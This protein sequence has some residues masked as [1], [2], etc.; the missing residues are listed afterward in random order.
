VEPYT[1]IT[2]NT[3]INPGA[4]AEE[5]QAAGSAREMRVGTILGALKVIPTDGRMVSQVAFELTSRL[6][7]KSLEPV[8]VFA[9]VCNALHLSSDRSTYRRH[10]SDAEFTAGGR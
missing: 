4:P 3:R 6:R 9:S 1:L 10:C 2:G 8:R 7:K 5:F